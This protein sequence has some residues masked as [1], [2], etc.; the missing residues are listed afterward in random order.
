ML[1]L[2]EKY[3]N[4]FGHGVGSAFYVPKAPGRVYVEATAIARVQRF[5]LRM[6]FM[7]YSSVYPV[8]VVERVALLEPGS[9]PPLLKSGDFVRVRNGMYK[10][11][12]GEVVDVPQGS[13]EVTLKLKSRE[14][15]HQ[16]WKR[17]RDNLVRNEPFVLVKSE[18]QYRQ[19]IDDVETNDELD[20]INHDTY[21]EDLGEAGFLFHGKRYT[22]DGHL[23]LTIRYDRLDIETTPKGL[24]DY[25]SIV[26]SEV[27][28]VSD[29][30]LEGSISCDDAVPCYDPQP[31]LMGRSDTLRFNLPK[32][33]RAGDPVRINRG[34]SAGAVGRVVELTSPPFALVNV[35]DVDPETKRALVL[36]TKINFLARIFEIG[37]R[38]EVK[39]GKLKGRVG[40]VS[41]REGDT[42]RIVNTRDFV[43]V[44]PIPHLVILKL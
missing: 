27:R 10:D 37:D 11:D 17:K 4:G 38:V 21:F 30:L 31:I 16:K 1:R 20:T 8:P 5:I 13:L 2:M 33:I 35:G 23:L 39:I 6:H 40:V 41:G 29:F 42:L 15:V 12:V 44:R 24:D 36:E 43:E 19:A 28:E 32:F 18:L 25:D 9:I 34:P 26:D 3:R 14:R 22:N 7:Y